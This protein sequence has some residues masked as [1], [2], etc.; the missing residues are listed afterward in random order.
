M[1]LFAILV[2]VALVF[3][4]LGFRVIRPVEKGL[5]ERFGKYQRTLEQ[6][7]RWVIP[8]VDR[9]IKVNVTEIRLDIARQQVITKDNLNLEI[10]G[11]VYFR[12]QEVQKAIY[13]VNDFFSSIPSL[14]QTTLRSVIGEMAFTEVNAQRQTI[15][16]KIEGELDSQTKTWGIDILRVELQD[17]RPSSEVQRAMDKVVTA[18]REKEAKITAATAEKEASRQVAEANI[19]EA[20]GEKTA[21]I[22][23][24]QGEAEAVRVAAIAKADAIRAVN[25]AI[26]ESFKDKSQAFKALE[27]TESSLRHN[28]K[29]VLTEKGI[30]PSIVINEAGGENIL[31]L[32]K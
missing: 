5:V 3:I 27:V 26:E 2:I 14:A 25:T 8:F 9:V 28:T 10:D 32:K 21:Q 31:P 17:V 1:G 7:L 30:N 18:E 6:G 15:N 4:L 19:I 22:Q 24:A 23:R 13:N 29:F 12:V 16:T 11:V 20:T